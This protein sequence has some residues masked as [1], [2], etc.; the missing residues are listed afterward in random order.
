M[1]VGIPGC[2]TNTSC[3]LAGHRFGD[4]LLQAASA[5]HFLV[6]MEYVA[7]WHHN[8]CDTMSTDLHGLG[9]A[10]IIQSK[11][12]PFPDLTTLAL[13]ASPLT[14]WSNG[15]VPPNE[16]FAKVM[17]CQPDL[18]AIADICSQHFGLSGDR[19]AQR[20]NDAC[21]GVV[22][23]VMLQVSIFLCALGHF[24]DHSTV[25]VSDQLPGKVSAM[26]KGMQV[27]SFL[28]P[29]SSTHA[30]ASY[31]AA[32]PAHSLAMPMLGTKSRGD[33]TIPS[34]SARD[35]LCVVK[36]P[37]IVLK[38][39]KPGLAQEEALRYLTAGTSS[40]LPSSA[41]PVIDLMDMGTAGGDVVEGG[42]DLMEE[43]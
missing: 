27:L 16:D 28:E 43:D 8:L 23:R 1:Q 13:Y 38:Y 41:Q 30:V 11:L 18:L 36:I 7:H 34:G 22:T 3:Q 9:L 4:S 31:K 25:I 32:I 26:L 15:H 19:L 21:T 2:S 12:L 40:G 20:L 17:A 6:F 5:L 33:P 24:F 14:L 42:A 39:V 29:S 10:G 37:A 35:D